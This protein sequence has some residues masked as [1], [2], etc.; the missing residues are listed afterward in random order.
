MNDNDELAYRAKLLMVRMCGVIIPRQ[1]INSLLDELFIAIQTFPVRGYFRL[2]SITKLLTG[3]D[4]SW[5]VR[6]KLLPLVQG[7]FKSSYHLTLCSFLLV[8]YFRQSSLISEVKIVEMVE[9][10]V[11]C[12][13]R[14]A[15]RS[16]RGVSIRSSVG[17]SMTRW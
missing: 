2:H 9:V 16:L 3:R 1:F 11:M 12:Y 17:A 6:L 8:F 5:K 4:Q 14:R 10:S 7:L 13:R 15:R